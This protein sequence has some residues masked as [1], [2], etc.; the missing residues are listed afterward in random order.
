MKSSF[1]ILLI[2]LFITLSSTF[3][4]AQWKQTNGPFC[5]NIRCFASDGT[6][7]IAGT[8]RGGVFLSKDN[9]SS[10]TEVNTGLK[11]TNISSLAII[12]TNIFAGTDCGGVWKRPINEMNVGISE[13]N[14]NNV[15]YKIYPNPNTG[16]FKIEIPP[17]ST[18]KINVE[19]YSLLG[20]KIFEKSDLNQ[21][22]SNEIDIS[23]FPKGIYF[24]KVR[25]GEKSYSQKVVME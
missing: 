16:K 4:H 11:D 1:R 14:K 5:G 19:I 2:S 20:E 12:G 3:L 21:P 8:E 17:E 10:W 7:I 13:S 25:D 6:N 9:G 23:E 22:G 18:N 15:H 24:V